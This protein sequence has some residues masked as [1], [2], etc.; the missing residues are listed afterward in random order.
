MLKK[1]NLQLFA[2][3]GTGNSGT[4]NPAGQSPAGAGN[5][6]G[7]NNAGDKGNGSPDAGKTYTQ[8][9]LDKIV[10]ERSERAGNAALASFY[11]QNGMTAEEAK[12]AVAAFKAEKAK[13]EQEEKGN[14]TAMQKKAEE[15]FPALAGVIL[16]LTPRKRSSYLTTI[17][18]SLPGT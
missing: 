16:D 7:T 1:F 18:A 13:K 8:A 10:N 17:F 4:G 2:E 5:G 11:Q 15:V 9:D 6:D 3:P 12:E 14:L